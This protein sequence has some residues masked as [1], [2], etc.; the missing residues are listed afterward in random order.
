MHD[1]DHVVVPYGDKQVRALS[2]D[3]I[4]ELTRSTFK[5]LEPDGS[6]VAIPAPYYQWYRCR[7]C[8]EYVEVRNE[9]GELVR[10][11]YEKKHRKPKLI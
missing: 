3:E 2:R 1:A 5:D 9:K 6:K 11:N 4:A 10:S 7:Y 8:G